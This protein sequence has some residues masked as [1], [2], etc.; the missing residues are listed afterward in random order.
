[1]KLSQHMAVC[2]ALGI[3]EDTHP[4]EIAEV[5]RMMRHG[6]AVAI[7]ERDEARRVRDAIQSD[8]Q[9]AI[10]RYRKADSDLAGALAHRDA[11]RVELD[12]IRTLV[13]GLAER[14]G[15]VE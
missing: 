6:L 15:V 1:M 4:D 13:H 12:D 5:A 2:K 9:R 10:E 3:S 8:A 11:L 14:L 7:R